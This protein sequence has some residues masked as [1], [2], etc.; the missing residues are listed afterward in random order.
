[1]PV[2]S[3]TRR[4]SA[5]EAVDAATRFSPTNFKHDHSSYRNERTVLQQLGRYFRRPEKEDDKKEGRQ[6][7]GRQ[8]E[9]GQDRDGETSRQE[10]G[11][12]ENGFQEN[13]FQEACRQK[14]G[15]KESLQE[16][17]GDVGVKKEDCKKEDR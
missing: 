4:V 8:K 7:K 14:N 11:R 15:R 5:S 16:V 13:R 1:M 2:D 9:D 6:E 17:N 3:P 12:Q 10:N